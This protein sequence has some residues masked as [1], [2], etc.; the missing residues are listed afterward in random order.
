MQPKVDMVHKA[1]E[2]MAL[3]NQ[4]LQRVTDELDAYQKDLDSMQ[5][6]HQ[7]SS[8]D[9]SSEFCYIFLIGKLHI[10]YLVRELY[11]LI[12]YTA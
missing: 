1:E 2:Q 3:V 10:A 12:L 5:V 7:T 11:H 9:P 4:D 6:G 8:F